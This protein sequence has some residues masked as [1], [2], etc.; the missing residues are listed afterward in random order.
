MIQGANSSSPEEHAQLM[1]MSSSLWQYMSE[2]V[3]NLMDGTG[4]QPNTD[5]R[6]AVK[7]MTLQPPASNP[8]IE[9]G[10]WPGVSM[11]TK[12]FVGPA[13]HTSPPKS[14]TALRSRIARAGWF[15]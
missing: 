10:S 11:K 14:A 9:T 1:S 7:Q 3:T 15:N 13:D 6:P 5:P 12:P 4:L 2:L 8:V